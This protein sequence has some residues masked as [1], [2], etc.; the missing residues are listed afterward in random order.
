MIAV[1]SSTLIDFMRG[2]PGHHVDAFVNAA[3]IGD[4]VVP[5]VVLSEVLSDPHLPKEHRVLLLSW[6]LLDIKDGFWVR[7]GDMRARI[8]S[9]KLR[10]RLPDTLIAQSC[11][12]Y[13]VPLIARDPDFRHFA[14]HC[15]LKLV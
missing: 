5:P 6:P 12:D 11:L 3:R 2:S 8:L 14:K 9:I 10:A 4:I 7:A 13:N 15:G 1:D